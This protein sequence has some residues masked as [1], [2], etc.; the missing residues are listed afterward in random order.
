MIYQQLSL[1]D[2]YKN[3]RLSQVWDVVCDAHKG[4]KR[5]G[6]N[7]INEQPDYTSHL[8]RTMEIIVNVLGRPE[9]ALKNDKLLPFLVIA[10]TH[11]MI[12]DTSFN[13]EKKLSSALTPIV[14]M[15][16]AKRIAGVVGELS[17][18]PEGFIGVTKQE[19]DIAKK[20]WQME[21]AVGMSIPA[22]MVKMADQ[23]SNIVDSVDLQMVALS[24]G[25]K[26]GALWS[27]DKK[28]AY[29]D[30]AL[31]VCQSCFVGI[32]R[33][34]DVQKDVFCKLMSLANAAY[35]YAQLKMKNLL[36]GH[37]DFFD[38]ISQTQEAGDEKECLPLM[39]SKK[40]LAIVKEYSKIR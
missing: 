40:Q 5:K 19:Q 20:K 35:D 36:V 27:D 14:G 22:K 31:S 29:A 17:N 6:L 10:L 15:G 11:D 28:K 1:S 33:V 8:F 26:K 25:N 21:H 30:K 34:S 9:D 23:I 4:Q 24:D 3:E 13:S 16:R 12:E 2:V 7:K 32:D 38:M 37:M 39:I 18:P